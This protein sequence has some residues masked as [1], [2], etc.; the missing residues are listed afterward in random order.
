MKRRLIPIAAAIAITAAVGIV[1]GALLF[2]S[3]EAPKRL[4]DSSSQT[5]AFSELRMRPVRVPTR[6]AGG[7]CP[8]PPALSPATQLPGVPTEAALGR[9]PVYV[10]FPAVPRVLDLFPPRGNSPLSRSRWRSA[11]ILFIREPGF[12]GPVLVRGR[13]MDGTSRMGFGT[14]IDPVWELRLSE[15]SWAEPRKALRPWGRTL[16]TPEGWRVAVRHVRIRADGCYAFQIDGQ[17]FSEKIGFYTA[18]QR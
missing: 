12:E 18:F 7:N 3:D 15:S 17:S 9:G 14:Q 1:A 2:S 11:E 6:R 10:A 4:P 8:L 16:R 5:N 13:Q